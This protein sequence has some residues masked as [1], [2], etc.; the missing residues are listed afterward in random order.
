MPTA[1]QHNHEAAM[2]RMWRRTSQAVAITLVGLGLAGCVEDLVLAPPPPNPAELVHYWHFNALPAGTL[3]NVAADVSTLAG[4][5]I[6]Y[7]GSGAG[8]MDLVDPGTDLN[9]RNVVPAGFGLRP[10]NPANTR[11]L[12]IVA[13]STGYEDLVVTWAV[14]RSSAGAQ[15]EEFSYSIDGGVNW[16]GIG[17]I[18]AITETWELKTIDL[19]AVTVV[20]NRANL[21]FRILFTGIGSDGA[22][23]NNRI[24]NLAIEG[25]PIT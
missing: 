15:Q 10:R 14:Q 22:S 21:R 9:A 8:Y 1:T 17:G 25:V 18:L 12:I 19:S 4:A 2:T 5:E 16:F 24:D 20:D 6:T 13:P 7:P 3:T 11:E 23:G